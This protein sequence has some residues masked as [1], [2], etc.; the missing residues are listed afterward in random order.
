MKLP[1]SPRLAKQKGSVRGHESGVGGQRL[2]FMGLLSACC[3]VTAALLLTG[4]GKAEPPADLVIVNGNEPE[5]LDPAIITGLSEMR[6]TQG[7]WAGLTRLHPR[8]VEPI[9]DLADRWE[10][11]PDKRIYTFHLRT[12]VVWST[13]EP[14][15]A[16]DFVYSWIR[17]LDPATASDY[18]GQL[19]PIK[20]AEEF[21]AGKIKDPSLVGVRALGAKTL[22]VELSNPTAFFLDLCAFPTLNIVPRKTIEKYGDRWLMVRPLPASGP[23]E[24]ISWRINDKI[25]MR[26][27]PRYWDAVNVHTE[28][29][30]FL[31]IGSPSTALNLYE[32]GAA[33]VVWDKDL[34]PVELLD[35]LKARPDYHTFTYL[36]AYFF[37][38]NVNRKPLDDP[39]VRKAFALVVDKKRLVEKITKAGEQPASHFVPPGVANY[40]PVPGLG[41][42]PAKARQLLVE[43]GFPGG[44]GFP[45]FQYKFFAAAGGAAKLHAKIAVELQQMWRDE[46]GIEIELQQ[47]ERKVFYAAQS[48]L[49]YDLS[50]SSWIGDYNDANTFLDMFMSNNG[51][52][53]TGWS[54]A[55]YDELI[56]AA[57]KETD[58]KVREKIFQAAETL[59]IQDELP[60]VPLYF[61]VGFNYYDPAKVAGIYPNILDQHPLQD[62]RKISGDSRRKE[63]HT[64]PTNRSASQSRLTSAAATK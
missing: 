44:K 11:S 32:T 31:P 13:G 51:N 17:A 25:R 40:Q 5:S 50:Q 9:P 21:N 4:C 43:A 15:T 58:L 34:I 52:N 57:N 41:F 27:N 8:T 19:F 62:I 38:F 28:I 42:D 26:K 53:R 35:D 56:R 29:F 30:D 3:F 60:I 24:L 45:R 54:H 7:L 18:A 47:I 6:L 14:I 2:G 49:D 1:T 33:D 36:G 55:R 10:I 64:S 61:Y 16:A 37:R 46:L 63:A 20:N 39:R 22:R 12:N 48:K 23:Y 59:L